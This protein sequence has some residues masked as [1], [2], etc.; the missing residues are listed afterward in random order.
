MDKIAATYN[1][2][3]IPAEL[4]ALKQ[5]VVWRIEDNDPKKKV[6]KHAGTGEAA[7]SNAP[8]TWSKFE[9][10][11]D[12][13][14]GSKTGKYN[15]VGFMLSE[16]D[17]YTFI[18]LDG[19]R[20]SETGEILDWAQAIVDQMDSYTEV[21]QSEEGIHIIVRGDK[22]PGKCRRDQVEIYDC[23]R[24]FALTGNILGGRDIINDRQGQLDALHSETFGGDRETESEPVGKPVSDLVLDPNTQL[25][26]LKIEE[27]RRRKGFAKTYDHKREDLPS[28][29]EYDLSLANYVAREGGSDQEIANIIIAFRR[30]HGD[31]KDLK[32]ALRLDYISGVIAK[33]RHSD[34]L[35]LLPFKVKGL[36]Q[37]GTEDA[38]YVLNLEDGTSIPMGETSSFLSPRRAYQR[39]YDAGH[40]LYPAA[41]KRWPEIAIA[42]RL[43]VKVEP[44]VTKLEEVQQWII[45]FLARGATK[46][47]LVDSEH[48]LGSAMSSDLAY[49]RI[50]FAADKEGRLFLH[51]ASII[52][53]ARMT[54]GQNL[55]Q[56]TLAG[57]LRR[58][59]FEKLR[60]VSIYRGESRS[61]ISVWV[62]PTG[63][64][65]SEFIIKEVEDTSLLAE[66]KGHSED[67]PDEPA[68]PTA[69]ALKIVTDE[70]REERKL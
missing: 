5:W 65:P 6:P 9:T 26:P 56:K 57:Y 4:K 12:N 35:E 32:K 22:P 64:L 34:V 49:D 24:Y 28:L 60:S 14:L 59:G 61:Q 51:I 31:E 17:P 53:H 37:L 20:D 1:L 50:G 46:P 33:V 47:K 45:S 63:F 18:D 3:N 16:D 68:D 8:Y 70:L 10:A 36:V 11:R 27:L 25:P 67:E 40:V 43:L 30:R 7:M 13:Y 21:S 42:L 23:K 69:R 39:L 19:V 2:D 41:V 62:S 38:E 58:I 54:L 66:V 44:T 48:G 29:S 52:G 15:G 55:S